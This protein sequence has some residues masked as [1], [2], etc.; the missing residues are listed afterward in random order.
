[1]R[2]KQHQLEIMVDAFLE[3]QTMLQVARS[4]NIERANVCRIVD[5]LRRNNGIALVKIGK[6]PITR[7]RAGFYTTDR[8]KFPNNPQLSLF[9]NEAI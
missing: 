2:T 5:R 3:P 7:Y 1:M 8:T 6:C 4:T 9:T